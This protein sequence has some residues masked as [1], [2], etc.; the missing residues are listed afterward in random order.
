MKHSPDRYEAHCNFI[1]SLP[2]VVCS[3]PAETELVHVRFSDARAAKINP[4]S[5]QKPEDNWTLPLC[6]QHHR[7]QHDL[8]EV[9]FWAWHKIDPT[10]VC[11]ALWINSGNTQ[12]AQTIINT[13]S[14]HS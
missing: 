4:G 3:N 8:G 12:A 13:W 2:C 10:F 14:Q 5:A 9:V 6:S 11:M 1:R 7:D